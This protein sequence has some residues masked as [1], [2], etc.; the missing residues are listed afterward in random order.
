MTLALLCVRLR[1]R[2]ILHMLL[3]CLCSGWI[4]CVAVAAD[5]PLD[6]LSQAVVDS[7]AHPPRTAPTELLDAA[8]KASDVEASGVAKDYF[9]KLADVLEAAG[10]KRLDLLADLGDFADSG[11]L[12]R[13]QRTL[14]P[15]DPSVGAPPA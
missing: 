12:L 15:S 8:I 1:Q 6:S 5:V 14:G 9:K 4:Y 10:D 7:L 3:A 2:A 11:S 13:L